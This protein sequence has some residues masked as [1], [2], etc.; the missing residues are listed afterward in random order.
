MVTDSSYDFQLSSLVVFFP[1]ANL[2]S[3]LLSSHFLNDIFQEICLFSCA[4]SGLLINFSSC[5]YHSFGNFVAFREML[6]ITIAFFLIS[7]IYLKLFFTGYPPC[8]V[9]SISFLK[10]VFESPKHMPLM[11]TPLLLH[12]SIMISCTQATAFYSCNQFLFLSRWCKLHFFS[13]LF[14]GN[15]FWPREVSSVVCVFCGGCNGGSMALLLWSV[16]VW[17]FSSLCSQDR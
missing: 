14:G 9:C 2:Y 16:P 1:V 13:S 6:Q 17:Q 10:A 3:L 11:W 15:A 4:S 5:L 12:T 7:I 8:Y